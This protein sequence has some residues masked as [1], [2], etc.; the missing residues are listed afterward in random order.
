MN[1]VNQIITLEQ[2]D[3]IDTLHSCLSAVARLMIPCNDLNLV[4]RDDLSCLLG[5][6]LDRLMQVSKGA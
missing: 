3:E 2:Q 1:N 5:Y 4:N 6:L